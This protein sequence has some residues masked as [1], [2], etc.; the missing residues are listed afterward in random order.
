MPSLTRF[1]PFRGLS[2]LDPLRAL[3]DWFALRPAAA[4]PEQPEIRVEVAESDGAFTVKAE[5]PGVTKEDIAVTVEGRQVA[6][7][8]E[9]KRESEKKEG[10]TVIHSERYY[11]KAY[12]AFTLPGEVDASACQAAYQNGI[13]TLTLPRAHDGPSRRIAVR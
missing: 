1:D 5:I 11:G 12:R 2:R 9:I 13:L 10:K 6:I 3:D 8:A 4:L 7:A